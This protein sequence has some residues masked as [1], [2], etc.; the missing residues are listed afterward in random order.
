MVGCTLS[1]FFQIR[2]WYCPLLQD[3]ADQLKQEKGLLQVRGNS[4]GA[5][6]RAWVA[7]GRHSRSQ[8]TSFLQ[9]PQIDR[10]LVSPYRAARPIDITKDWPLPP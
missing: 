10:D 5:S 8:D 1:A 2:H 3:V 9:W 6:D 7:L 4:I